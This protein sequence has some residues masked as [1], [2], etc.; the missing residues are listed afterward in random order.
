MVTS[1]CS[2]LF[3]HEGWWAPLMKGGEDRGQEGDSWRTV[4]ENSVFCPIVPL[5]GR[6]QLWQWA[7]SNP[8]S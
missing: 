8:S 2:A 3:L 5:D 4:F 7:W 1:F 6:M